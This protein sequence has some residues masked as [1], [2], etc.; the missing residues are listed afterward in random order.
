MATQQQLLLFFLLLILYQ[1]LIRIH[2][3]TISQ[4]YAADPAFDIESLLHHSATFTNITLFHPYQFLRYIVQPTLHL[5]AQPRQSVLVNYIRRLR[6]CQIN[7]INRI[8]RFRL[9]TRGV[10]PIVLSV[11]FDQSPT[12]TRRDIHHTALA[13]CQSLYPLHVQ[14]I[15]PNSQHYYTHIG[16]GAFSHFPRAIYAVDVAKV[17]IL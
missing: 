12:T 14:P 3:P 7:T 17:C 1:Q 6:R 16:Q 15:T 8:L 10:P 13:M 11:I 2:H 5:T 4:L 9:W